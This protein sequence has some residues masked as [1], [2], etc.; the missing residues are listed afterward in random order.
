MLLNDN[1][2]LDGVKQ[3]TYNRSAQ[4]STA[5]HSTAQH[6]TAQ[7]ST[8]QHSTAQHS[9]AQHSTAPAVDIRLFLLAPKRSGPLGAFFGIYN[10]QSIESIEMRKKDDTR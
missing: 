2:I 5:Q 8:A 3:M 7:H 9:T 4:H 6:S 10:N 1:K